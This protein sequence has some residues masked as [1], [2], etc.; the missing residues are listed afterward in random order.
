MDIQ[1]CI[2]DCLDCFRTCTETIA[3]CLQKGGRHAEA[4]HVRLLQDC[5]DICETAAAFM[6]RR[7]DLHVRT[8]ALCAE[9]CLRCAEDCDRLAD[10]ERMRRCA[11]VC[12]RCAESCRQMSMA[13]A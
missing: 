7:S 10:D 8:C 9:T 2:E 13:T 1:R 5:A 3:Y 4:N 6:M 11:E 12:R